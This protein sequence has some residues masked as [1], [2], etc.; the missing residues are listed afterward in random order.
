MVTTII[1]EMVKGETQRQNKLISSERLFKILHKETKII[2]IGQAVLEILN[3][4]D[5]DLDNL[6][7]KNDRKTENVVF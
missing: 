4:K 1:N 7:R 3:F 5:R 2:K 6:T